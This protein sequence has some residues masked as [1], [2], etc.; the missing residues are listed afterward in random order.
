MKRI[1]CL[2]S[3]VAGVPCLLACLAHAGGYLARWLSLVSTSE[4]GA[5][6]GGRLGRR[7]SSDDENTI[8]G[9]GTRAGILSFESLFW[10]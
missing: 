1:G 9:F 6:L 4:D 10:E 7:T 8:S 5:G 3:T 2:I